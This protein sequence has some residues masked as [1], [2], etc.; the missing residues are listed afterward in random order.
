MQQPQLFYYTTFFQKKVVI[1]TEI[2]KLFGSIF[3]DSEKAE[4]SI[5]KT[6]K[7][8][9]S[10]SA[11]LGK[12]IKTAAKWGAGIAAGA[13]AAGTAMFAMATKT[14]AT[15]D[16]IDK[17][18]QKIGL[19]RKGFQEWEFIL[20][21]NGTSIETMQMG[22]KT[23]TQ[24]MDE[25]VKGTGKG[26][27][28]FKK[29]G[30]SVKDTAGNLKSQEQVFEETVRALQEMPDGAEKARLAV[31]LFGRSGQELMPLLN[32]AAGSVDE[33]KKKANELGLVLSDEAIDAGVKFTDT[34]DQ[35]KRSFGAVFAQVGAAIIPIFQQL[36]EWIMQHMP[37]IQSIF[38]TVFGVI[39]ILVNGFIQGIQLIISWIG[40]WAYNNSERLSV[41]QGLFMTF[42]GAVQN[43]I[44]AFVEFATAFWNEFGDEI[45]AVVS[46]A[47]DYIYSTIETVLT[48]I[49]EIFNVFAALFR[50]DWEGLAEGV[51]NIWNALWDWIKNTGKIVYD[52]GKSIVQAL[53]DGIKSMWSRLTD[54]VSDKI[55]SLINKLNPF[56]GS[57]FSISPPSIPGLAS[58]GEITDSGLALVGENGPELLQL[59]RGAQ[60]IP[61]SGIDYDSFAQAIAK[62]INPS[63]T[64]N[65]TIN[66]PEPVTPSVA[67]RKQEQLLRQLAM[68]W[69][70]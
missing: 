26:A 21:Q 49:T 50:G 31:E 35:L 24:R 36:A 32:G 68:E 69:G 14:A 8:A 9:E 39:G 23:M 42:F 30:I 29:L 20:S 2:F 13:T 48:L 10:L 60:V 6:E 66:S 45:M 38:Q 19:S 64:L 46:F 7:K 47:F 34:M 61:L 16:R 4:Q 55:S 54:W 67:K 40:Q 44:S 1:I 5:S 18:S 41:L 22:L 52:I 70:V 33:L 28:L 12:G 53:W 59:P 56:K 11:K 15:T 65:T 43:F 17:L 51:K 37:Q 62:Y 63:I 57:R 27:E 3:I 58:G 25:T